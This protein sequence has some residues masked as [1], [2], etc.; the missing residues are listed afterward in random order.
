[1]P[2]VGSPFNVTRTTKKFLFD[3]TKAESAWN[4]D[5]V[6]NADQH[7]L[8][9]D[10]G[11]AVVGQ[12]DESNPQRIPTPSQA[13]IISSTPE[14]YWEGGI[15]AWGVDLVKKGYYVETLPCNGQITYGNTANVQDLSN[16]NV[17]VVC[18]PNIVFS[19]KLLITSN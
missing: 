16:Y 8:G 5:W 17:F 19:A 3:A 14:D 4:A 9:F 12:G 18:E 6:I 2:V 1:L 13:N 11:P 7:N 10:N 15:S